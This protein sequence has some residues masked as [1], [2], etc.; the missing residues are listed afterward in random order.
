MSMETGGIIA[1]VASQLFSSMESL[2]KSSSSSSPSSSIPSIS[3]SSTRTS[4]TVIDSS[5]PSKDELDGTDEEISFSLHASYLEI[6]QEKLKDLFLPPPP[7][8]YVESIPSP[9][10]RIRKDPFSTDPRALCIPSLQQREISSPSTLGHLLSQAQKNKTVAA[11]LMNTTSSRAHSILTLTLTRKSPRATRTSK[12]H[13]ID[14]AGSERQ[15]KTGATGIRL[16]EAGYINASLSAL[17]NVISILS[18]ANLKDTD[19]VPFRDSKLTY[20]LS[21]SLGGEVFTFH[22]PLSCRTN[23]ISL[24]L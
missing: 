21:D 22:Y 24:S 17:G 5:I 11:T 20:L 23:H 13:L 7:P 14:L 3:T 6:Y 15:D 18:S 8:L 16:R 19:H 12:L 1:Q 4:N 9:E 2:T 10:L